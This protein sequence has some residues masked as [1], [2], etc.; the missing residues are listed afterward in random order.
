MLASISYDAIKKISSFCA[1]NL[2]NTAWAYSTLVIS[3]QPLLHATSA[4]VIKKSSDFCAQNFG[5]TA[6]AF[7]VRIVEDPPLIKAISS[8]AIRLISDYDLQA[9]AWLADIGLD[10]HE[11]IERLLNRDISM[12]WEGFPAD[13]EHFDDAFMK[14]LKRMRV[15]NFGAV[16]NRL[17]L[18]YMGIEH[19]SGSLEDRAMLMI[20]AHRREDPREDPNETKFGGPT[21]HKR[22]FSYAEYRVLG[23]CL[24]PNAI[25]GAMIQENG[26]RGPH[27]EDTPLRPVPLPINQRVERSACSEFLLL[28][29]LCALIQKSGAQQ[30]E[31][32]SAVSGSLRLYS[33]GPSCVSCV[34]TIWQFHLRFPQLLVEVGY[35]KT[36]GVPLISIHRPSALRG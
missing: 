17:L 24:G 36:Q 28:S 11:E 26:A 1:Q 4:E 2:T 15:D 21:R 30:E 22:V 32:R 6:W 7:A 3:D 29:E 31:E 12:V 33:T 9:L 8:E 35:S 23:A 14:S 10:C 13:P 5:N 19:A 27:F 16:G 25:E 20:C 18:N 34:A